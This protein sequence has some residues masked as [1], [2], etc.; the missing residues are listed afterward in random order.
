MERWLRLSKVESLAQGHTAGERQGWDSKPGF[1]ESK[2]ELQTLPPPPLLA[3]PLPR[4]A[5]NNGASLEGPCL[6]GQH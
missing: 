4:T 6:H 2:L 3:L 5:Q 1:S